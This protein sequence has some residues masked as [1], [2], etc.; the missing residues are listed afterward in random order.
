VPFAG[1]GCVFLYASFAAEPR[2]IRPFA[3]LG[4]APVAG[5][6]ATAGDHRAVF[7]G[8]DC[9]ARPRAALPVDVERPLPIPAGA[10]LYD[11]TVVPFFRV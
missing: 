5:A 10:R 4:A 8:A 7:R 1:Q 3:S 11:L 9:G 6:F 2:A